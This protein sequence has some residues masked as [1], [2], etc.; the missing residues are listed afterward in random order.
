MIGWQSGRLTYILVNKVTKFMAVFT[1]KV[2]AST[3]M[4]I[5]LYVA[6]YGRRYYDIGIIVEMCFH[7]YI[8]RIKHMTEH[9]DVMHR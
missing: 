4:R 1:L 9:T 3:C 2:V 5:A 8:C 7:K 6:I